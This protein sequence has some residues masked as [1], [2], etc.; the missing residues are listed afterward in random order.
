MNAPRPHGLADWEHLHRSARA[1]DRAAFDTLVRTATPWLRALAKRHGARPAELDEV[2]Q[3][4]LLE[5][6]G[7]VTP[8]ADGA[9]LPWLSALVHHR[10]VA[11]RRIAQRRSRLHRLDSDAIDHCRTP[12]R[13][14]DGFALVRAREVFDAVSAAIEALPPEYREIV[15]LHLFEAMSPAAIA[16]HLGLLRVT[17]RVRLFR[18]LRRLRRALP[19]ALALLLLLGL[20]RPSAGQTLW[21]S[22]AAAATLAGASGLY[23]LGAGQADPQAGLPVGLAA[24]PSATIADDLAVRPPV[25]DAVRRLA[26]ATT[27]LAVIVRDAD[28]RSLPGV[29]LYLAATSGIDPAVSSLRATTGADGRA[30]FA[31]VPAA[32]CTLRSDRGSAVAVTAGMHALELVCDR[33][34][35]LRGRV[36]DAAGN[37]IESARIWLSSSGDKPLEGTEVGLTGADGT[38]ALRDVQ[39]GSL[40]AVHARGFAPIP[41]RPV[42]QADLG[43]LTLAAGGGAVRGQVVDARHRPIAQALVVI[44]AGGDGAAATVVRDKLPIRPPP[45]CVRTDV[46]GRF[47]ADGLAA[48][49]LPVVVRSQGAAPLCSPIAIDPHGVADVRL[50]L[51]DGVRLIGAVTDRG[52]QPLA[53]ARVACRNDDPFAAVDVLAD[54]SGRVE[55]TAL[56]SGPLLFTVHAA[57][58]AVAE[59][60]HD[61]RPGS[62]TLPFVVDRLQQCRGRI[63]RDDGSPLAGWQLALPPE[64]ARSIERDPFL[65]TADADGELLL[66]VAPGTRWQDLLMRPPGSALW[67]AAAD[68]L[69]LGADGRFVLRV[70]PTSVPTATVHLRLTDDRK[71]PLAHA[72]VWL[73]GKGDEHLRIGAADA[74]GVFRFGPLFADRYHLVASA[75][76]PDLPPLELPPLDIDDGVARA[77]SGGQTSLVTIASPATGR[78][79][80]S[81]RF[82]DGSRPTAP[83][84]SVG[85]D[86]SSFLFARNHGATGQ[87]CLAAG[88]YTVHAVG[89]D[90]VWFG[91]AAVEVRAGAT[92]V[93]ERTVRRACRRTLSLRHLPLECRGD[94][95]VG[96]CR[97]DRTDELLARFDL[98]MDAAHPLPLT[99]FLPA[100]RIRIEAC[101]SA[102]RRTRAEVEFADLAPSYAAV[103]VIF[104]LVR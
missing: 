51:E 83:I 8:P 82:E 17:V 49:C 76:S 57:D 89:E 58:C 64:R 19:D 70:P 18:G 10:V 16:S 3:D 13:N 79:A 25:A 26:P 90:F 23:A 87:Q 102:G 24:L 69:Q 7:N 80:W 96:T 45:R 9:F 42:R 33:G 92:T 72:E 50:R 30:E 60:L 103:P 65:A 85:R 100:A 34:L 94:R 54:A 48:G 11:L 47:A 86:T 81:L 99:A 39:P 62:H 29:G 35:D 52:G 66:G 75:P 67:M 63:Q 88:S 78:L 27:A 46:E 43:D 20:A 59:C 5:L 74:D 1:G 53:G 14:A 71:A 77:A 22:A 44:G 93:C 37:P 97:D 32:H 101:S 55:F 4:T 6:T 38:F 84:V 28:G 95:L 98:P 40:L 91:D 2:V 36:V 41:A 15:H 73:R 68:E 31:N 21:W 104:E 61:L 12:T 56:P